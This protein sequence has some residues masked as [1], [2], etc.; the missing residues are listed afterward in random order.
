MKKNIL[1]STFTSLFLSQAIFAQGLVSELIFE[2]KFDNGSPTLG[3]WSVASAPIQWSR[4]NLSN[5]P[6]S[7]ALINI[8]LSGEP[9]NSW[10]MI[11]AFKNGDGDNKV[12]DSRLTS[13]EFNFKEYDHVY[14]KFDHLFRKG[15]NDHIYVDIS[16]DGKKWSNIELFKHLNF[17]EFQNRRQTPYKVENPSTVIL[18]LTQYLAYKPKAYIGFRYKKSSQDLG[19]SW[20]IDNVELWEKDPT[21]ACD[22]AIQDDYYGIPPSMITPNSQIEPLD[23]LLKIQNRSSQEQKNIVVEIKIFDAITGDI[24]FREEEHLNKLSKDSSG[25]KL[26]ANRFLPNP[27]VKSYIGEYRVNPTCVDE[28]P[29]NNVQRFKFSLSENS[30]FQKENNATFAIGPSEDEFNGMMPKWEWGNFYRV[31]N[32]KDFY[33]TSISFGYTAE[34]DKSVQGDDIRCKLYKWKNNNHNDKAEASELVLVGQNT[35]SLNDCDE[36]YCELNIPLFDSKTNTKS[37]QLEDST[38]YFAVVEYVPKYLNH[39]LSILANDTMFYAAND[40]WLP[41]KY[42]EK[43]TSAIKVGNAKDYET[44]SFDYQMVP[45]I[46]LHVESRVDDNETVINYPTIRLFPNPTTDFVNISCPSGCDFDEVS[47]Q[48]YLGQTLLHQTFLNTLDVSDL[49]NGAY[50]LIMKKDNNMVVRKLQIIKGK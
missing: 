19:F 3:Y 18:D 12:I 29:E 47:I 27:K 13:N 40:Y 28:N 42:P 32:G 49:P 23:F 35:Q 22:I 30:T 20:Q 2:D 45:M 5:F 7:N 33:A 6:A 24:L 44:N 37:I 41:K 26:F 1:F 50:N 34:F 11:D 16:T 39:A 4:V 21:P 48:N 9:N 31:N 17:I 25:I 15:T 14:L 10:M 43:Y 8:P 46:R 38:T 36:K